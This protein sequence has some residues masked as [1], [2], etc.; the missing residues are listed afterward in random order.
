MAAAAFVIGTLIH[1]G[2]YALAFVA[3]KL[4]PEKE[5]RRVVS[6][7]RAAMSDVDLSSLPGLKYREITTRD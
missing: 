7:L 4:K 6:L 3:P 2:A 1:F 5:L